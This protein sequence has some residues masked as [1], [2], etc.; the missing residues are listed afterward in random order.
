MSKD[1]EFYLSN[2]IVL[3]NL[4]LLYFKRHIL[5][6]RKNHVICNISII[7]IECQNNI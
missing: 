3:T 4:G 1:G 6:L 5:D 7:I 2:K